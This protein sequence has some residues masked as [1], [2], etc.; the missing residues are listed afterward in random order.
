MSGQAKRFISEYVRMLCDGHEGTLHPAS[1]DEVC[2][3]QSRPSQQADLEYALFEL[4]APEREALKQFQKCEAYAGFKDPRGITTVPSLVKFM[5]SSIAYAAMDKMH[6]FSP[7]IACGYQ[8]GQVA[9]RVASIGKIS[10]MISLSDFHRMDGTRSAV[11]VAFQRAILLRMFHPR[12][13][14]MI[15]D[16]HSLIVGNT[17]FSSNGVRYDQGT[18]QGSGDPFTCWANCHSSALTAY[19]GYRLSGQTAREAWI[20]V[21]TKGSYLGD[22]GVNGDL[23]S[24][25]YSK[26]GLLYGYIATTDECVPGGKRVQFLSRVYGPG[27]WIG[28]PA[29]CADLPRALRSLP[30]T[31]RLRGVPPQ[32]LENKKEFYMCAK[33]MS[34]LATDSFTPILGPMC[35]ILVH[36]L[37]P[38]KEYVDKHIATRQGAMDATTWN[39]RWT[40]DGDP[41]QDPESDMEWAEAYA[42]SV[43]S[44]DGLAQMR[45]YL[46]DGNEHGRQPWHVWPVL[47]EERIDPPKHEPVITSDGQ[48]ILAAGQRLEAKKNIPVDHKQIKE[49][50]QQVQKENK[51]NS[52]VC[53]D[54]KKS[55]AFSPK[56]QAYYE[57]MK[58]SPPKR[59]KPCREARNEKKKKK[60]DTKVKTKPTERKETKVPFKTK[61]PSPNK[62]ESNSKHGKTRQKWVAKKRGLKK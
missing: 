32:H 6:E 4:N 22:D 33:A 27:V 21:M 20:S 41:Y 43:F 14:D 57:S 42:D 2:A 8:P 61:E 51:E 5:T 29:N 37:R 10:K 15:A 1:V 24:K 12:Y 7:F 25:F 44:L 28:D 50:S 34:Y 35:K 52:I 18:M 38:V 55:F 46:E 9:R 30:L 11:I 59:C 47:H 58:F 62:T 19:T 31:S 17:I 16:W 45:A 48:I 56:E 60:S 39:Y 36:K 54:C 40:M 49:V 3:R 13:H 26:A 23:A 53:E